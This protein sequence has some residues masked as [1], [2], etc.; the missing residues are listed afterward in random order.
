L[1]VGLAATNPEN[2]PGEKASGTSALNTGGGQ[3][4]A[5]LTFSLN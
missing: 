2:N 1:A 5:V 3:G 4:S